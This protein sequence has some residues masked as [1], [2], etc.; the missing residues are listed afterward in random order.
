MSSEDLIVE[1]EPVKEIKNKRTFVDKESDSLLHAQ[2]EVLTPTKHQ[3]QDL[4]DFHSTEYIESEDLIEKDEDIEEENE[5]QFCRIYLNEEELNNLTRFELYAKWKDQDAYID[6]LEAQ[7]RQ[8][9]TDKTDLIS[10]R[11]S[12]EK[13]KLQQLEA[14]RR[15]NI[16]VMRLTTK[17]QEMQEYVVRLLR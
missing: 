13:L 9:S 4:I 7:L 2:D 17:E 10:L 3:E 1:T 5:K 14:T 16:L 12:E 15:E 11:E 8:D 6:S